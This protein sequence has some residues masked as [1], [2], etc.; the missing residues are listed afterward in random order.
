MAQGYLHSC[1]SPGIALHVEPG[2]VRLVGE[3][4]AVGVSRVVRRVARAGHLLGM[5]P[6]PGLVQLGAPGK[7]NHVG[8]SFPMRRGP[9]ELESDVLGRLAGFER[10]H[11]VDASVFPSIPATTVTLTAMATRTESPRRQAGANRAG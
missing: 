9:G 11:I 10:V 3:R 2:R 1:E 7:S 6:I 5:F 4:R 8:G